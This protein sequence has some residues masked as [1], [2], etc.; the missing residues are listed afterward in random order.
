MPL[1]DRLLCMF[2]GRLRDTEVQS[3]EY[4]QALRLLPTDTYILEAK[5]V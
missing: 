4:N 1:S 3:A 2:A 5:G